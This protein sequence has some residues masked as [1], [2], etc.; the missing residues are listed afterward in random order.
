[1][2]TTPA[3]SNGFRLENGRMPSGAQIAASNNNSIPVAQSEDSEAAELY[4]EGFE[5]FVALTNSSM[6][7]I[8]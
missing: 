3:E 8:A 6:Q 5:K 7:D 2:A 4:T 1:M